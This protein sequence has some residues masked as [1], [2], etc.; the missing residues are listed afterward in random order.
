MGV[1]NCNASEI[2]H[3]ACNMYAHHKFMWSQQCIVV[4]NACVCVFICLPIM[5]QTLCG[6]AV[7]IT[8]NNKTK[9]TTKVEASELIII[10]K[11]RRGAQTCK[12]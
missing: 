7:E 2:Q 4:S 1:Y 11:S 5:R 10:N 8:N 9:T 3:E 6:S 12:Q